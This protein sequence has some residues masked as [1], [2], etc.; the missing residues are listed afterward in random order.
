MESIVED[1]EEERET[2]GSPANSE[3][4]EDNGGCDSMGISISVNHSDGPS[5]CSS[6]YQGHHRQ[7]RGINENIIFKIFDAALT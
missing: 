6:H 3:S 1:V 4:C 2:E 7:T 5:S